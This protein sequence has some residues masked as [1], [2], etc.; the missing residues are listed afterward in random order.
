MFSKAFK[1]YQYRLDYR[2][3]P[4]DSERPVSCNGLENDDSR[5]FSEM[6]SHLVNIDEAVT[7]RYS[8]NKTTRRYLIG[9][10]EV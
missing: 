8:G 2:L 4:Y 7:P 1:V 5:V 6:V 10:A 9:T 3:K